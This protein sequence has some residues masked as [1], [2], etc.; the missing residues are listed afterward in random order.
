MHQAVELPSM[1]GA[2]KP[3]MPAAPPPPLWLVVLHNDP[4]TPM[5]FVIEV[6]EKVFRMEAN[7]AAIIML[8]VHEKGQGIA[9]VYSKDIAESRVYQ[10]RARAV[11]R[12]FPLIVTM[13]PAP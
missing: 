13:E 5:D 7:K 8:E 4:I 6:L 2:V 9:G 11:N 10:V 1:I 12:G 3:E